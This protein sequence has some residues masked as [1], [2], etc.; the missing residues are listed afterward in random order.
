MQSMQSPGPGS[1][2]MERS[3]GNACAQPVQRARCGEK[4][5]V[6]AWQTWLAGQLWHTAHRLYSPAH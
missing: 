4:R 1:A 2:P 3:T 6:Q 5:D